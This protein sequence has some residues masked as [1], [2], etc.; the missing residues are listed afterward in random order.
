M[1]DAVARALRLTPAQRRQL[2]ALARGDA[3]HPAPTTGDA[4][5]PTA[6]KLLDELDTPAII[7]GRGTAVVASNAAHHA[8]T[9][10]FS[11]QPPGH[12]YYATG[13][14]RSRR[15]GRFSSTGTGPP[16]RRW[17]YSARLSPGFRRMTVSRR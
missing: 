4:L 16:E 6:V 11:Q 13:Y 8:L 14:L 5:R 1:L 10:D 3:R 12:R 15:R 7:V 9:I 2:Y 17:E